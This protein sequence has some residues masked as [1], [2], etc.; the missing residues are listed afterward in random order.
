M[1]TSVSAGYWGP[2]L[3]YMVLPAVTLGNLLPVELNTKQASWAYIG[4]GAYAGE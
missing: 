3:R 2:D 1:I 4:L